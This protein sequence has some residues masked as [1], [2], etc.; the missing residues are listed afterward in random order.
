MKLQIIDSLR[1]IYHTL[2]NKKQDKIS[3]V[4]LEN[5][6]NFTI[7]GKLCTGIVGDTFTTWV[8]SENNIYNCYTED[9][10]VY[11]EDGAIADV[12]ADTVILNGAVYELE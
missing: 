12:T 5:I 2:N 9:D 10:T 11:T 3:I 4:N 7:D 6:I 1:L 8:S